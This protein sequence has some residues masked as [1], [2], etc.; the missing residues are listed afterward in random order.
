M[1]QVKDLLLMLILSGSSLSAMALCQEGL[2]V[3]GQNGQTNDTIF[4]CVNVQLQF[5]D[6]SLLEGTLSQ[7]M[8][9]FG[10]GGEPI[11]DLTSPFAQHTYNSPGIYEMKMTVSSLSCLPISV[12]RTIV[13]LGQP[14]FNVSMMGTSCVGSCDGQA[15]VSITG[16][17]APF[18]NFIWSDVSA[19]ATPTA[20]NLCAGPYFAMIYDNYGCS[21]VTTNVINVLQP[22]P[23]SASVNSIT[24]VDCHGSS[25]GSVTLS[26][27][28]GPG[29]FTFDIGSGPQASNTFSGLAAGDHTIIAKNANG[30]ES[31]VAITIV[32]PPTPLEGSI[33]ATMDVTCFG[34]ASGS[35]SAMA[36]GGTGAFSFNLGFGPQPT[37]IFTGLNSGDYTL[38][39]KD[40][41]GCQNLLGFTINE[42]EVLS[43]SVLEDNDV[44]CNGNATGSAE[45]TGIGGTAP[46][47]Y[48]LG[49]GPQSSGSF[50]GLAAG[51]YFVT[52][53]DANLCQTV[54]GFT[55]NEPTALSGSIDAGTEPDC[56][57]NATGSATLSATGGA[58]PYIF[59]I[60]SG[61]QPT[62][63]FTALSAGSY[64][65]TVQ[66]ANG[67]QTLVAFSIG[68]PTALSGSLDANS[69][70]DCN[71]NATGSATISAT[72]GTG[73]YTFDI[74]S[75]QQPTGIFTA[76]SAGSYTATVQ[77]ANGC[78]TLVPFGIGEPAVLTVDFSA[79]TSISLC[80]SNGPT[81]LD[82]LISGG[83]APFASDW[84]SSPEL[85]VISVTT[86]VLTPTQSSVEAA[87]S[88]TITDFNGC[89]ATDL[90][91]VSSTTSSLQGT[92]MMGDLPCI[93]CEVIRYEH[94]AA[95]PGVWVVINSV[96]TN[97][98]G[99]YNFGQVDNFQ[100][101]V[102]MADPNDQF[103]PMSVETF[104]PDVYDWND[105]TV[106]DM[107]GNNFVKNIGVIEP[108]LF[109][110]S[111]IIAGTV[112]YDPTGKTQS[113]Q[114]PIPLIDVVVEKTPPGQAQGRI[115][116][117][118]L[119]EYEFAFVPNSDTAYSI[120]VNIPGV[121]V[122]N[123]YEVLVN[124]QGQIFEHLDF[125]VNIDWTQIETCQTEQ[126]LTVG[127]E[128]PTNSGFSLY[129]NPNNGMFTI[130]TG[131]F[132]DTDSDIRIMDTSGRLVFNKNYRQIPNVVNIVNLAEGYYIV[133]IN[134]GS[135]SNALPISVL[136]NY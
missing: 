26:V 45:V 136:Q 1:K 18:Y 51:D 29:P 43:A 61:Q 119:G 110:G 117:N 100:H 35:V 60:G 27:S 114:D 30:C 92:L 116:T 130:N 56:N 121:P 2:L 73:P 97:A 15:S 49:S 70:A 63:I 99:Q 122:T 13:V 71:G 69:D 98:V 108:M 6:Q 102:L 80:P 128:D 81:P 28:G 34:T 12:K 135:G 5:Q 20:T 93:S 126:G 96:M 58:G 123:T 74:G 82:I 88:V 84:T 40:A 67:C 62:G 19:Q 10:D 79:G 76:L 87:Y 95:D 77:D 111:G 17:N 23:F 113:E 132:A 41:N 91:Q 90:I 39:I 133:Q 103:Y 11:N 38:E 85:N 50:S 83:T 59:D 25:T 54:I 32:E 31:P 14:Q 109:N 106:F 107:C 48:D 124:N 36:Y 104:Y 75:G 47:S 68:E 89:V 4:I 64:T 78:Q 46:Y 9:E 24:Q 65:A 101:F 8:W 22:S 115:S 118:E 129:P 37:G 86:A 55:T 33:E 125:C 112:W 3:T 120:F 44:D 66:D 52:I 134:N 72:G 57:G 16:P 127:N 7:R 42:P 105:A 131:S 53:K 94:H 21:D